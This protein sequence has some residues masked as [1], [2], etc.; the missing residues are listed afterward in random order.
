MLAQIMGDQQKVGWFGG[1]AIEE[2]TDFLGPPKHE[3]KWQ[4]LP[5]LGVLFADSALHIHWH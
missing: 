3:E 5:D 2:R 1:R 4:L